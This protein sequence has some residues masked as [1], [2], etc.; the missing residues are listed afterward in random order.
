MT[1][2]RQRQRVTETAT[3]RERPKKKGGKDSK[4]IV[5]QL[6]TDVSLE[7]MYTLCFK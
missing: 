2:E 5:V 7:Q 3:E 1:E 4:L 6:S